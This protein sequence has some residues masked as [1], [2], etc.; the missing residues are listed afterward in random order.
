MVYLPDFLCAQC[1]DV[2]DDD[3]LLQRGPSLH[4]H[5]DD[6]VVQH[7]VHQVGD[8]PGPKHSQVDHYHP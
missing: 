3:P 6:V 2:R 7:Q 8:L 4:L 5:Q 1:E